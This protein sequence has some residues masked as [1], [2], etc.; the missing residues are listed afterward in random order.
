V[1]AEEEEE[2][3]YTGAAL[4]ASR[5]IKAVLQCV[6]VDQGGE[7]VHRNFAA[8]DRTAP[9]RSDAKRKRPKQNSG[10]DGAVSSVRAGSTLGAGGAVEVSDTAAPQE[11]DKKRKRKR[12]KDNSS[13]PSP[14]TKGAVDQ[15]TASSLRLQHKG[16]KKKIRPKEKSSGH[17]VPL[18]VSQKIKVHI[19]VCA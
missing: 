9:Q 4:K 2:V 12:P 13:V 7:A 3:P 11:S 15:G 1:R 5:G 8:A 17:G 19:C 14:G 10:G 16:D 6:A 18:P